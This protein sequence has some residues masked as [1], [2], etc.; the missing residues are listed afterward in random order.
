MAYFTIV[1]T[2]ELHRGCENL[3][4]ADPQG[5]RALEQLEESSSDL[6]TLERARVY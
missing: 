6:L 2:A 4:S 5:C 1:T 3:V